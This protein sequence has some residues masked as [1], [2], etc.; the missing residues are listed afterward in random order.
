MDTISPRQWKYT[1]NQYESPSCWDCGLDYGDSG[2]IE[3]VLPN[4]LWEAI[5]PSNDRGC[6][7][8]CVTCLLAGL[9]GAKIVNDAVEKRLLNQALE[10]MSTEV[11]EEDE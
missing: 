3:C 9:G 7:L 10:V 6:G 4:P 1:H 5:S 11:G 8:L 2:W